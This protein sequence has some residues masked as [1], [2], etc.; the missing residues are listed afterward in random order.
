MHQASLDALT[1]ASQE[2]LD[3]WISCDNGEAMHKSS[4]GYLVLVLAL[5]SISLFLIFAVQTM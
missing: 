4:D 3:L 1:P 2:K 5:V